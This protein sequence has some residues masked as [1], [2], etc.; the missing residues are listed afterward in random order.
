MYPQAKGTETDPTKWNQT[1]LWT[2]PVVQYQRFPNVST[3]ISQCPH[4]GSYWTN[5][6]D[7]ALTLINRELKMS[8]PKHLWECSGSLG[9]GRVV[10]ILLFRIVHESKSTDSWIC[11]LCISDLYVV[12]L[13]FVQKMKQWW[14]CVYF[15]LLYCFLYLL[16]AFFIPPFLTSSLGLRDSFYSLRRLFHK[17]TVPSFRTF[18]L[19]L[20]RNLWVGSDEAF[21]RQRFVVLPMVF[22]W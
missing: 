19:I 11:S 2:S 12:H 18:S 22:F 5:A 1:V 15:G 13:K 21:F 16:Q 9:F 7:S 10:A 8:F 17:W 4:H 3:P 20:K 14:W 6:F